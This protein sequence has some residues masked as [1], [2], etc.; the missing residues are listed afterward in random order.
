[1]YFYLLMKFCISENLGL[2]CILLLIWKWQLVVTWVSTVLVSRGYYKYD[3]A[4]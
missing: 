2:D 4:I 3:H 1:M